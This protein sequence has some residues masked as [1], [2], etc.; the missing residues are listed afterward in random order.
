MILFRYLHRHQEAT[1]NYI[2]RYRKMAFNQYDDKRYS[3]FLPI[4][5][6]STVY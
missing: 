2:P 4:Q 6:R 5:W 3:F 1:E